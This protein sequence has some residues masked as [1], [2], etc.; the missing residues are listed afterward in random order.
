[1][2][3]QPLLTANQAK[4]DPN[5]TGTCLLLV[6]PNEASYGATITKK[7][8]GTHHKLFHTTLMSF[9]KDDP[10]EF[11]VGPSVGSPMAVMTLEKLIAL[12]LKKLVV[13]GW[14]GSLSQELKVGDVFIPEYGFSDEGVSPHYPLAEPP[15]TSHQLQKDLLKLFPTAH[16]GKIWT[17][18]AP[19][20]EFPKD[21]A[22]HRNNGLKAVD[23]EFTALCTVCNFYSI[24]I[25]GLM[26]VS[27]E[28]YHDTWHSGIN[29][30]NFKKKAKT[31]LNR[32]MDNL[33]Q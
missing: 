15:K 20:R 10:A 14:C 24:E 25:A 33:P 12:G 26:V 13:F 22:M 1:M 31:T 3:E 23:M 18:D 29:T 9:I 27:D 30:K 5:I 4:N 7:R 32:L 28:L 16:S 2:T 8:G 6:N 17:T 11:W 21:I 19:F